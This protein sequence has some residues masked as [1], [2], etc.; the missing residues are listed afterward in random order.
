MKMIILIGPQGSGN[1]LFSKIFSMHDDVHGWKALLEPDGYF[2]PHEKEPSN[3]YWNDPSK[4]DQ[5]IMGG[6]EFAV[7]SISSTYMVNYKPHIPPLFQFTEQL[8]KHEI[9]YEVVAIG[10][11]R[12]ILDL[13]QRRVRGGPT[14]GIMPLLIR[15]LEKPPFFVSQELLYLYRQNYLR[16]LAAW[17]DFPIAWND[18]RVEHILANDANAK[19]VQPC[20]RTELDDYVNNYNKPSWLK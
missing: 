11:D 18:P 9:E 10:R 13:Q 3:A 14:W 12:N 17:L 1:H 8:T 4:I 5:S 20:E 7:T 6:K 15:N 2:I 19:Y 16:S